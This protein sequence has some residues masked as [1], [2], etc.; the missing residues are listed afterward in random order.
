MPGIIPR[1]GVLYVIA[2]PIG[3]PDDITYRAIKILRSTDLV[4]AEDTRI[5]KRLLARHDV[6]TPVVSYHEHNEQ[7]QAPV[8]LARLERGDTIALVS[9]A[10]TPLVS[11]PGYRLV[12]AAR[13]H[14]IEVIPVPGPC[15]ATA[16]LCVSGLSTS[17]FCFAGFPPKRRSKRN[18][19]FKGFEKCRQTLVFYLP[20]A[21]IIALLDEIIEIIGDRQA[22]LAREMTKPHEEYLYGRL[23]DIRADLS[24]RE[25]VRGEVTLVV[26]G[27]GDSAC[28][29]EKDLREK[30][31]CALEQGDMA[32][33]KLASSFAKIYGLNKDKVY[34]MILEIKDEID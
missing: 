20:P 6:H 10:G 16:A 5:A 18:A 22:F 33:S 21:G 9:D 2:L 28:T 34:Q 17:G 32:P 24:E 1:C 12:S 14:G 30:L 4:A 15:A 23:S 11:D 29:D 3:N 26:A 25:R 8:L 13:Q 31:C 19:F 27:A 7:K